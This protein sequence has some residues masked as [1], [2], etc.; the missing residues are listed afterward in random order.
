[1]QT[2]MRIKQTAHHLIDNLP[3]NTTWEALLYAL[4]VRRDIEA[5][6]ADSD[7]GKLLTTEELKREL[8]AKH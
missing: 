1:M 8:S 4:Q 7:D 3:D 2:V 6:I 5:G